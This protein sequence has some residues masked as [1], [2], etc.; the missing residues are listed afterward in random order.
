M[1]NESRARQAIERFARA[2]YRRR[3]PHVGD[4]AEALIEEFE[5]TARQCPGKRAEVTCRIAE[6]DLD[7]ARLPALAE[8]SRYAASTSF[9]STLTARSWSTGTSS[10]SS[11]TARRP[12]RQAVSCTGRS[13]GTLSPATG[14]V[15]M[16]GTARGAPDK[17][18]VRRCEQVD[19]HNNMQ[20]GLGIGRSRGSSACFAYP[21]K[22]SF[23]TTAP[24]RRGRDLSR[25]EEIACRARN[26]LWN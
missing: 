2:Y 14:N 19:M 5:R 21:A 6:D 3:D 23:R 26:R 18:P 16:V 13:V 12:Q 4:G 24:P 7:V 20:Y 8:R 17:S 25:P 15:V 10:R 22:P 9:I 1:F 11:R